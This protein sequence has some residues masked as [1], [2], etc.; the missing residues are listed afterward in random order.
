MVMGY[1]IVKAEPAVYVLNK[2]VEEI[3]DGAISEKAMGLSLSVGVACSL[4]L[5]RIRGRTGVSIMWFL[6]PG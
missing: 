4:G 3:T 2:Q 5:S 6:A 1:F